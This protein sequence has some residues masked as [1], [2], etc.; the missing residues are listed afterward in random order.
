[1]RHKPWAYLTKEYLGLWGFAPI[2]EWI[3]RDED[4][5]TVA[6]NKDPKMCR[7]ECRSKGF[8]PKVR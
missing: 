3:A 8:I 5:N 6:R 7:R 1:M 4:G 2:M